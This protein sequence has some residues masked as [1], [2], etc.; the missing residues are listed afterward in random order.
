M[1]ILDWTV[2][3]IV[4]RINNHYKEA[5]YAINKRQPTTDI[6]KLWGHW[7][8]EYKAEMEFIIYQG[9]CTD[10]LKWIYALL[11]NRNQL[12]TL[13]L[14]T[15]LGKVGLKR[16]LSKASVVMAQLITGIRK[17]KIPDEIC[18]KVDAHILGLSTGN[19]DTIVESKIYVSDY[20][21][22]FQYKEPAVILT[23]KDVIIIGGQENA[24]ATK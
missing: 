17:P 23:P 22:E 5:L 18:S 7:V 15:R 8:L 16:D 24:T 9:V 3:V 11:Q 6:W 2:D 21:K 12:I 4:D 14:T 10:Q 1:T 13:N 20:P 19:Y